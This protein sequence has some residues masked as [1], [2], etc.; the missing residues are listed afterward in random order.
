[1][2]T[3]IILKV[4]A[5]RHRLRAYVEQASANVRDFDCPV[6]GPTTRWPPPSWKASTPASLARWP[7]LTQAVT[8]W[9]SGVARAGSPCDWRE[10]LPA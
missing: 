2:S 1:M 6:P 3:Q 8:Y 9:R 7:L 5:L 10:R 4:L